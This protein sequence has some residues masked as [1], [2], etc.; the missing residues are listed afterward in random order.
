[1]KF[2]ACWGIFHSYAT[3]LLRIDTGVMF[4]ILTELPH[5]LKKN[6]GPACKVCITHRSQ[7][8]QMKWALA[9]FPLM[10]LSVE[11]KFE[12]FNSQ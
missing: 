8:Q 10:H 11:C 6:Q 2:L 5:Y 7:R 1:M 12:T 3:L 9:R 4:I